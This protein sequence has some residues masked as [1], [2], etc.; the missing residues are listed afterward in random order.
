MGKSSLLLRNISIMALVVSTG[1]AV[2][3]ATASGQDIYVAAN[4]NGPH[5]TTIGEYT[6]SGAVVNAPLISGL[7]GVGS[8]AVSGSDLYIFNEN[9]DTISEYTTS[10]AA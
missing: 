6:T 8:I 9:I 1:A 10:G 3:S 5:T 2:S 4:G 7:N